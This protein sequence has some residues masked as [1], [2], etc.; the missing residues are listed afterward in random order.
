M[1]SLYVK[2]K[3]KNKE[4]ANSISIFGKN[5]LTVATVKRFVIL[6]Q[7]MILIIYSINKINTVLNV[8]IF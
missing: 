6:K 8:I 7:L 5:L 2:F 3:L 1:W 4:E